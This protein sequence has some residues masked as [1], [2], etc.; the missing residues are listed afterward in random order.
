MLILIHGPWLTS[1][2]L[3][4]RIL[5]QLGGERAMI[6]WKCQSFIWDEKWLHLECR[7][8]PS[9]GW[10]DPLKQSMATHNSILAW[11]ILGREEPGGLQSQTGL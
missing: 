6:D 8:L 1:G 3:L 9:L 11:R 5:V 10:E 7:V 2:S 4:R